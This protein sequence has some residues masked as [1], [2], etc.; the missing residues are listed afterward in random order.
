MSFDSFRFVRSCACLLAGM[1]VMTAG[2]SSPSD[3]QAGSSGSGPTGSANPPV[4]NESPSAPANPSSAPADPSSL[5]FGS[6]NKPVDSASAPVPE[7]PLAP[8]EEAA[9]A[10]DREIN[11]TRKTVM[12][13]HDKNLFIESIITD[14]PFSAAVWKSLLPSSRRRMRRLRRPEIRARCRHPCGAGSERRSRRPR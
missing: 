3:N 10:S 7:P 14:T 6:E 12:S 4:A 13:E 11:A 2:C 1:L 8:L 5:T 9:P